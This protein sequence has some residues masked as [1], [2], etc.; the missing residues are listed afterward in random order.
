MSEGDELGVTDQAD[1]ARCNQE[2]QHGEVVDLGEDDAAHAADR[3]R[4]RAVDLSGSEPLADSPLPSVT[5]DGAQAVEDRLISCVDTRDRTDPAALGDGR[6]GSSHRLDVRRGEVGRFQL[7]DRAEELADES[8]PGPAE[9]RRVRRVEGLR[10][11]DGRELGPEYACMDPKVPRERLGELRKRRHPRADDRTP[12][13]RLVAEDGPGLQR[14]R[15]DEEYV[16][17]Q[18]PCFRR[19]HS[20]ASKPTFL[21]VPSQNG[22]LPERPQRQR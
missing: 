15:V 12:P 9:L 17:A 19:T 1:Q 14:R 7:L 13:A 11:D 10:E 4:T 8:S 6:E 5:V 3:A 21:C 22:L 18:W 2:L 16:R 20:V